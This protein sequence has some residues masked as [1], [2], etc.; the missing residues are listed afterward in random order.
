MVGNLGRRL[1]A[2]E[3]NQGL[4][5][6][7]SELM[8]GDA[9]WQ[10]VLMVAR[11]RESRGKFDRGGG[12]PSKAAEDN[13]VVHDNGPELRMSILTIDAGEDLSGSRGCTRSRTDMGLRW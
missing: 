12:R 9:K 13:G 4:R 6:K 3:G 8:M 7:L 2:G 5:D 1:G 11:R 10:W